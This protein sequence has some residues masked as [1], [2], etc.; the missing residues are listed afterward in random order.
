MLKRWTHFFN[1]EK[2][3]LRFHDLWVLLP[4]CPLAIWNL[5]AF[6]AIGD[7]LGKFM[8]VDSKLLTVQDRRVGRLLVEFDLNQ[9]LHA[10]MDIVWQDFVYQ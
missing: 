7:T 1:L 10:K 8:H 6:K 5:E 4:G 9:G 2:E 3:H